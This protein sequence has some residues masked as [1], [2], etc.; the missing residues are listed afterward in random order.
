MDIPDEC[1]E[2]ITG[3]IY[4]DVAQPSLSITRQEIL[5]L[6]NVLERILQEYLVGI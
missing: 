5:T 1:Q 4:P 3:S 2:T 6:T